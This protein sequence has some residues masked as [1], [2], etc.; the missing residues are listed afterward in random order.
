MVI[1][2][3]IRRVRTRITWNQMKVKYY[4]KL[5][6]NMLRANGHM[7]LEVWEYGPLVVKKS[8]SV[9]VKECGSKGVWSYGS[10]EVEM[11]R[12]LDVWISRRPRD[13]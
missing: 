13:D 7:L 9:E 8:R 3:F 11:F 12:R 10:K 5:I 1:T 6:W 2:S 4:L